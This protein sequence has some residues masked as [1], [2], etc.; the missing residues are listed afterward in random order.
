L[1]DPHALYKLII[2]YMLDKVDFPLTKAQVGD[3]ILE[4]EYTNFITLQ[5]VMAE[6]VESRLV[7]AQSYR[8]RTHL[9][10]TK[11]GSDTIHFFEG[12]ISR[13]IKN[14]IDEFFRKNS[15]EMRNESS[16]IADY[17]KTTQGDWAAHLIAKEKE[18]SLIDLTL[19][20][21]TEEI[22]SSIC[23]NWNEKNQL[24]YEFL[25]KELF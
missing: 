14:D 6:L 13:A 25:C 8:N 3:F 18:T 16:I 4:H 12:E 19:S 24:I 15:I 10:L 11:E 9:K 1:K 5:S 22:A 2:L 20:V 7:I 23:D 21:P 17:Y